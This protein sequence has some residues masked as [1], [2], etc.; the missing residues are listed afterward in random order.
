LGEPEVTQIWP[1]PTPSDSELLG[2]ALA[3]QCPWELPGPRLLYLSG[4][5]GAGKTTLAAAML[6]ALGVTEAVRSP[7][8]ALIELYGLGASAAPSGALAVH[9]DLYRLR[10][11]E[12]LVQL[13]IDDY[14]DDRTLLLIE[15]PER[16]GGALPRPDVTLMLEVQGEG[17]VC[18][19]EAGSD[20]GERWLRASGTALDAS[21]AP[22]Y[23]Q[24]DTV[25]GS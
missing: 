13:G 3:R 5:L 4:E 1:L 24:P 2:A 14:L 11:S 20:A 9:I 18:R 10:G 17:R 25:S 15:W 16:A 12:E 19:A 22:G 6:A 21:S 8:Y 7:T 23:V